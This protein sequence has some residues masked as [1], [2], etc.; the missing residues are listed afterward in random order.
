MNDKLREIKQDTDFTESKEAAVEL[1]KKYDIDL[2]KLFELLSEQE[3]LI[4]LTIFNPTLS[5]LETISKYLHENLNI[6]FKRI[7]SLM[8][9]SEKTIWQAYNF[10]LKKYDKRFLVT[11]TSYVIPLSIF[12][13]RKYSNL[14]AV[15]LFAKEEY[16]LRFSDLAAILHRDQ[17]T[18][19]TVYNRAL[20]KRAK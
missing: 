15:V 1:N 12:S 9:R 14:E 6:S 17:R 13:D 18:I 4:P 3:I 16:S 8:N 7:G 2:V 20:K 5:S 10:S 11:R 19:W